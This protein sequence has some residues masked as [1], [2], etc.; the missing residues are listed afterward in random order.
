[1]VFEWQPPL[2]EVVGTGP[3]LVLERLAEPVTTL[4]VIKKLPVSLPV[5]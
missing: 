1:M 5:R 2:C 3:Q 4:S